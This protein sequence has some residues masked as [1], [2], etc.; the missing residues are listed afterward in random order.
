MCIRT[1]IGQAAVPI[2]MMILGVNL[3]STYRKKKQAD[4]VDHDPMRLSNI[5][6]LA[7]VVG[8]MVAMPVIGIVS[9]WF[10][11]RGKMFR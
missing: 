10:F 3:S 11:Q 7:V 9:T 6:M 1:Q 8:K 4:I 2:N 5:T